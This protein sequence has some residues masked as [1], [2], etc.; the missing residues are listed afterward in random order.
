M[1]WLWLTTLFAAA[2][3]LATVI[4]PLLRQ[5][6][7]RTPEAHGVIAALMG[8]SRR[9]FGNHF[10]IQSDVYLHRG[11]YPSIFDHAEDAPPKNATSE[12]LHSGEH[13]HDEH[14]QH[15][16]LG[17]ARNWLDAFGRYFFPS[18][19]THLGE[20]QTALAE[21]RE[22][23]PWIKFS[24]EMDPGRVETYTVGAYWLRQIKRNDE[25][26][27]FLREGMRANPSSYEIL[28]ELGLCYEERRDMALA[29][30]L[31]ELA[32]R[33]WQEQQAAAP[34]PDKLTLAQ[35]LTHLT[36]LEVRA[37]RRDQALKYLEM[38][39]KV[40]PSP[41][42]IQQRIDDVKAGRSFEAGPP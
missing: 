9:L 40:S 41:A 11:Y 34:E 33:R 3:A 2:F 42:R 7:G 21:A 14:C 15:D 31:W 17:Q 19:H 25:A 26:L 22:I 20:G 35:I 5:W 32:L 36:R 30:N 13:E 4:E 27:R 8:D 28:Y 38:L 29:R 37:N 12:A 24:A 23:L 1:P 10:F 6:S 39:K 18:Q 16:R